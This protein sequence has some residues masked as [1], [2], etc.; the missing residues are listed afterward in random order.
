MF[1]WGY[2]VMYHSL[3]DNV[4]DLDPRSIQHQGENALGLARAFGSQDLNALN[5]REDQVFFSLFPGVLVRYPAGWAALLA[6][7]AVL[8][9]AVVIFAGFRQGRLS[10]PGILG[11]TAAALALVLLPLVLAVAAWFLITKLHP[12]FWRNIM[13]SPYKSD[14]YLLGLVALLAAASLGLLGLLRRKVS[15]AHLSLGAVLLWL[16]LALLLGLLAPLL[17]RFV[18]IHPRL[19]PGITAL[20]ALGLLVTASLTSGFNVDQP[21]QNGVWYTLDAET[22]E[23]AWTSFGEQP[24]DPWT[25]QF[26]PGATE[27]VDPQSLYPMFSSNPLPPAAFKGPAESVSLPAPQ[28][29]ILSDEMSGEVRILKLRLTSP[30]QARGMLVK[31]SGAPVASAAVNGYRQSHAAWPAQTDWYLRFYGMTDQGIDLTLEVHGTNPISLSLTDQSDGLP[32]LIGLNVSPRTPD[33]MPFA[34]PQEYM[35]FPETTSVRM[36]YEIR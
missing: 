26:F 28:M 13:G 20:A 8:V 16:P 30:R 34:M 12:E 4:N 27:P 35:P 5:T 10:I 31:V 33:M 6:L 11:G 24:D 18:Q 7:L 3:L 25:A 19:V 36:T 29:Q 9:A 22:N 14:L 1:G 17:D 21:M 15:L 32:E 23:A 2:H